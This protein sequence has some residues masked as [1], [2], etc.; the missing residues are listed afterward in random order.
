MRTVEISADVSDLS[1]QYWSPRH[2]QRVQQ[3]PTRSSTIRTAASA[4]TRSS[5]VCRRRAEFQLDGEC[6]EH[7]RSAIFG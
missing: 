1:D 4:A 2:V 6:V 3:S 7:W 5:A